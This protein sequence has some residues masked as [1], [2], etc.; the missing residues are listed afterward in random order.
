M[1]SYVIFDM[2]GVIIDSESWYMNQLNEFLYLQGYSIPKN[3][4]IETMGLDING[5]FK[6]LEKYITADQDE[7]QYLFEKYLLRIQSPNYQQI[8]FPHV[9]KCIEN[10]FQKNIDIIIASS[11]PRE[12]IEEVLVEL[13]I[14]SYISFFLGREDVQ[15]TKPNPEVYL[16]VLKH[17]KGRK[18]LY[19][20]E[21][22]TFGIQAAKRAGLKVIAYH[23]GKFQIDQSESDF[24]ITDHMQIL[25]IITGGD[26]YD[27]RRTSKNV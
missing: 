13:N 8:V 20:V 16:S 2:D 14:N 24:I 1:K 17:Q 26:N 4:L 6:K 23:S 19:V 12:I 22:S 18:P 15:Y 27:K 7:I 21:D 11:S 3:E 5:I 10:I 9:Q 25:D